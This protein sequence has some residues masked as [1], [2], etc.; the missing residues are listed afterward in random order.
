M[1]VSDDSDDE[2]E[3]KERTPASRHLTVTV[4]QI[5][6]DWQGPILDECQHRFQTLVM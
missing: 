4:S 3:G 6:K 2:L 1:L 5:Y